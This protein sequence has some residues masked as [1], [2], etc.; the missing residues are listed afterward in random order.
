MRDLF[1]NGTAY[2]WQQPA[3]ADWSIVGMNHF[4]LGGLRRIYVAMVKGDRCIKAEGPD[5]AEIWLTLALAAG[6]Q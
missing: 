2:P 6:Q 1:E 4:Y 3:L 5:T